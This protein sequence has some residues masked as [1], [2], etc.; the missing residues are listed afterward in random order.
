MLRQLGLLE[1]PATGVPWGVH[2]KG[3]PW[4]SEQVNRDP[5]VQKGERS[6]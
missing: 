3:S 2:W 5:Q 4:P 1:A 6:Y